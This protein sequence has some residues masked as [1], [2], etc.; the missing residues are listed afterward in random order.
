MIYLDYAANTPVEELVLDSFVDATRKYIANPN[1]SHPLGKLAK[2]EI[3]KVSE[4]IAKYFHSSKESVIIILN[5]CKDKVL[6]KEEIEKCKTRFS[7]YKYYYIINWDI[8]TFS[9]T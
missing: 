3:D 8:N 7:K 4:D 1:S 2:D 5:D 9:I 6:K